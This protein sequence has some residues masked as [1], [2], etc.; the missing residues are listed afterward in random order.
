[1]KTVNSLGA[2]R[3]HGPSPSVLLSKSIAIDWVTG[4]SSRDGLMYSQ[5]PTNLG[6]SW[7]SGCSRDR[8]DLKLI[9]GKREVSFTIARMKWK[10]TLVLGF[11]SIARRVWNAM[12]YMT[13]EFEVFKGME[14]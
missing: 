12:N 13:N 4:R 2:T 1:V 7:S 11:R 9:S 3:A 5:A 6:N 8:S 14:L 10:H